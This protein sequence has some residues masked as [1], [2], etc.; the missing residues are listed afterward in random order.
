MEFSSKQDIP[1][2]SSVYSQNSAAGP[3]PDIDSP[4]PSAPW[5]N[6]RRKGRQ[7]GTRMTSDL[8]ELMLVNVTLMLTGHQGSRLHPKHGAWD[9]GYIA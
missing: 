3:L 1:V 9:L 6:C 5:M 7:C 8:R 4:Y 2:S